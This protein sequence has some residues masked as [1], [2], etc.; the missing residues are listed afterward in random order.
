M[1]PPQEF[2][3]LPGASSVVFNVVPSVP[4]LPLLP[5]LP[6]SSIHPS[7]ND[8]TSNTSPVIDLL[9]QFL[10]YPAASR[11]RAEDA[12]R[13]PWFVG[14]GSTLLLPRGYTLAPETEE[15]KNIAVC[16]WK[17]KTI[18]EWLHSVLLTIPGG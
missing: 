4:L 6:P 13:H 10:V 7:P 8:I 17:G 2:E 3:E 9:S 14:V 15:L 1:Q 18:G 16:E 11:L 12:I 5:N